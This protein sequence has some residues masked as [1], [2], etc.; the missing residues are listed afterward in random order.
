SRETQEQIT[1]NIINRLDDDDTK[2]IDTQ[3]RK[4]NYADAQTIANQVNTV[5]SNEHGT[6]ANS[7][8]GRPNF[9]G[10]FD[11]F[12]FGGGNN[13]NNQQTVNS[14]DP[15]GKVTADPR[16]NSVLITGSEE[17]MVKIN[18]LID[19]LDVSVPVESTTFVFPL[20]YAQAADVSYALSQAFGTG[21]NNN[22]FNPFFFFGGNSNQRTQ[23]QS[24]GINNFQPIQR[25]QTSTSGRSIMPPGPPN[26]PDGQGGNDPGNGQAGQQIPGVMTT[27]GFIPGENMNVPGVT[28]FM[29]AN[30]FVP[31]GVANASNNN[32]S[33]N[34][35]ARTRQFGFGFGQRQQG[36]GNTNGARYGRGSQ[37]NQ[38]NLLQ[39]Q[40]NVYAVPSPNGDSLIV[41]T[42]P[43][44]YEA[45]KG[46]IEAL[47]VIPSQVML[48]VVVA[49]VSLTSDD[50]FGFNLN[51]ALN[52]ILGQSTNVTGNLVQQ[53]SNAFGPTTTID[54]NLSGQQV[55]LSGTNYTALLQALQSNDKVRVLA[56]PRVF[57]SNNQ[58]AL[59]DIATQVPYV[60]G[61]TINTAAVSAVATTQVLFKNIGFYLLVT[62]RISRQGQVTV[63]VVQ[64]ASDLLT[65]VTLGSGTNAILAPEFND[66]YTDT[67]VTV[68]DNE[69]VVLGG[70]IR[71]R[72]E[73]NTSKLP[74]LGDLP[75]VGQFFRAR[76]KTRNKVELMIFIT[77]HVITSVEG[78]REMTKQQT[79]KISQQFPELGKEPNF[80][81]PD[82]V[83]QKKGTNTKSAP[84]K[85]NPNPNGATPNNG[86][87]TN[88]DNGGNVISTPGG[89]PPTH[90]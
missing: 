17:R 76:E 68:Q 10:F 73:L 11:P 62:P 59:I 50:K 16:T 25:H 32:D 52:H 70:L 64:D 90:P 69:T 18:A 5:L 7:S 72:T 30:G 56:T 31:S 75:L 66:R 88:P 57:T 80:P 87:T 37:G 82:P 27:R 47:D 22:N 15:F 34:P 21:Q 42:T 33:N 46:I 63:D 8:G 14:T 19:E 28:G 65:Y 60:D 13:N 61:Q 35:D 71:D 81:L 39:L 79:S 6:S 9:G 44:N 77:P 49:E 24:N 38:V 41:T 23:S 2:T 29:T 67:S 36:L 83:D 40:N 85:Q 4:I 1:R 78:A 84:K 53:P 43:D 12:G 55:L 86:G 74:L 48:D 51:G 89:V 26:A 20:K 54:P 3:I 58:Q 45:I